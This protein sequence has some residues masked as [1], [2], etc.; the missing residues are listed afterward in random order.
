[1]N[2]F[3]AT[4]NPV[5]GTQN[6]VLNNESRPVKLNPAIYTLLYWTLSSPNFLKIW[7]QAQLPLLQ[8]GGK[9]AHYAI[10]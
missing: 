5:V 8:R 3:M 7:L 6:L 2:K 1:M 10:V 4:K 9:G